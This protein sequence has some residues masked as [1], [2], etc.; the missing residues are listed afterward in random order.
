MGLSELKARYQRAE[1]KHE[2]L[3]KYADTLEDDIVRRK[4]LADHLIAAQTVIREIADTARHEF[5]AEV[6][7]LVTLAIK[8]VF[9]ENFS[10]DLQMTVEGGRLQCKPVVWETCE[11]MQIEYSPKDDM[12][13]SILD[14]IGFALR[15]VLHQ[16][17]KN[18]RPVFILDEP[19]KNVGHGELMRQAGRM[20]QEISHR[21]KLQLIV[22][23][24]EPELI[25]IADSAWKVVRN[26]KG[27]SAVESNG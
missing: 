18:I 14:P 11:N 19:M 15:V 1:G 23:T 9:S 20:L 22:I 12:G 24:H 6:D 5:K 17:Q 25:E 7:R 8:S 16:F 13:G 4:K 2:Q 21:L 3:K 10:F 26:K 27:E